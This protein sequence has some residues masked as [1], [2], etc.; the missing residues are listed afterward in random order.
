MTS[1]KLGDRGRA[2]LVDM[3]LGICFEPT[4]TGAPFPRWELINPFL[5]LGD[6][7]FDSI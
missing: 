4:G 3:K 6:G 7:A 2:A 1:N 5:L